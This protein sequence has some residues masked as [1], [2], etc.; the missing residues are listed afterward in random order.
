MLIV[1]FADI[2]W[3]NH[4]K[5][6]IIICFLAG[7]INFSFGFRSMAGIASM[8]GFL[9]IVG[10]YFGD[11]LRV[12]STGNAVMGLG[13]LA[14]GTMGIIDLYA[15]GASSGWFGKYEQERYEA[16]VDERGVLFSGRAEFLV[17]I[18]A[19]AERP[20]LGYGSWAANEYYAISLLELSGY[21]T[22]ELPPGFSDTIPTHSHLTGAWVDGGVFS[23]LFWIYVLFLLARAL[24]AILR[25]PQIGSPTI[26]FI[27]INLGWAVLF[28]PYG[29]TS[30][31]S[32]AL[33]ITVAVTVLRQEALI[34]AGKRVPA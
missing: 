8:T 11:R 7:A 21:S 23:A 1:A 34:A 26:I 6:A 5:N 20:I 15:V 12:F 27:L 10:T 25:R 13:V 19:I 24:L 9:L 22:E 4:K 33:A 29:L 18:D 2:Q 28:S 17:A 32:A 14:I 30:R 31:L 16:Q 3:S